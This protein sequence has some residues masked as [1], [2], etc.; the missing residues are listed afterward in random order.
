MLTYPAVPLSI[1]LARCFLPTLLI[2]LAPLY[3]DFY[4]IS[5]EIDGASD[6]ASGL[7]LTGF[8][9]NDE[10]SLSFSSDSEPPSYSLTGLSSDDGNGLLT[11]AI[12]DLSLILCKLSYDGP[13]VE[14]QCFFQ[15]LKFA[16]E[17]LKWQVLFDEAG[18]SADSDPYSSSDSEQANFML[19]ALEICDLVLVE[20]TDSHNNIDPSLLEE[21][22][23]K[24][25]ELQCLSKLYRSLKHIG[26]LEQRM[27]E[28][29]MNG[30]TE[31][32]RR[33]ASLVQ[34]SSS[35]SLHL[36]GKHQKARSGSRKIAKKADSSKKSGATASKAAST[37]SSSSSF[38]ILSVISI[39]ES[40]SDDEE[41]KRDSSRTRARRK[42][43]KKEKEQT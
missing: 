1:S 27:Q 25:L 39:S 14:Q 31:K 30:D 40:S 21:L 29:E 24:C 37:S 32:T 19:Y 9:L 42:H 22:K 17:S 5:V 34:R 28:A 3:I 18:P 43:P 26:W 20:R 38:K 13:I 6:Q 41:H 36:L 2:I 11:S 23:V 7:T 33:F 8:S 15:G 12:W 4:S 35:V 16:G 10:S